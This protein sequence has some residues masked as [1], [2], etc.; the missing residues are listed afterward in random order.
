MPE[1][2]LKSLEELERQFRAENLK[3]LRSPAK[4]NNFGIT[5]NNIR[6]NT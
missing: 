2:R 6:Q 5:S 3:E 1:T 4:N